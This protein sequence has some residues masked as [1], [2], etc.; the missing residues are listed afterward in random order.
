[1]TALKVTKI[2]DEMVDLETGQQFS[3]GIVISNGVR[4]EFIPL[5][6]ESLQPLVALYAETIGAPQV[7]VVPSQ[8]VSQHAR[9]LADNERRRAEARQ[10]DVPE[11]QVAQDPLPAPPDHLA[12]AAMQRPTLHDPNTGIAFTPIAPPPDEEDAPPGEEYEDELT[13][14][15][16]F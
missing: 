1:M 2:I 13:G 16:S 15:A 3:H 5:P 12:Q 4:E 8:E 9:S 7:A 6:K 11:H 10:A 14:V